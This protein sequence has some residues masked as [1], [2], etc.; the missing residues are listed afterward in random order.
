MKIAEPKK[1]TGKTIGD[2]LEYLSTY[3]SSAL[4]EVAIG[5]SRLDLLDNFRA[6]EWTGVIPKS[7]TDVII[8]HDLGTTPRYW[9]VADIQNGGTSSSISRGKAA[10]SGTSVSLRNAGSA[11]V[12]A[13]VIFYR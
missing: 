10:W 6:Y 11:S 9:I 3:L 4:R 8:Q 5:L 2:V 13:T 1:F 12:S 7:G